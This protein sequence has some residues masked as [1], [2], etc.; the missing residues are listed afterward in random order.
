[1]AEP[2]ENASQAINGLGCRPNRKWIYNELSD[3]FPHV[4]M[5]LTQ[6]NHEQFPI[7]WRANYTA[8]SL[9]RSI[10]IASDGAIKNSKICEKL[11]EMHDAGS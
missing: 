1:M 7:D 5:P 6:P 9:Q 8:G 10:F 4:Y 2:R 3:L 11:V